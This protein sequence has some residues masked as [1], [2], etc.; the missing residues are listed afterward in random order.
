MNSGPC[1]FAKKSAA[2][3]RP[4]SVPEHATLAPYTFSEAK[5]EQAWQWGETG[6][7]GK[8]GP[9]RYVATDGRLLKECH[10]VDDKLHGA[11]VCYHDD[12]TVFYRSNYEHGVERFGQITRS[13][14]PSSYVFP[15]WC[16]D[17][18]W[19]HAKHYD[20]H[21]RSIRQE[22]RTRD[23]TLVNSEGVPQPERPAH[24]PD[25]AYWACRGPD[26]R[27]QWMLWTFDFSIHNSVG[28][29]AIWDADG[30]W[31]SLQYS[32]PT[33]TSTNG[34]LGL[35]PKTGAG[36]PNPLSVAADQNDLQAVEQLLALG[37]ASWPHMAEYLDFCC[38]LG[39]RSATRQAD[40][41]KFHELANRVR[42]GEFSASSFLA[43]PAEPKRPA[44]KE[45]PPVAPNAVWVPAMEGWLNFQYADGKPAGMWTARWSPYH[46]PK[47]VDIEFQDGRP[48]TR[49]MRSNYGGLWA[50]SRY[51]ENGSE[52]NA[53]EYGYDGVLHSEREIL[54]DGTVAEREFFPAAE[55]RMA[56]EALREDT[57]G[58]RMRSERIM[59]NN[60]LIVQRTWNEDGTLAEEYRPPTRPAN[61]PA[62]AG[63]QIWRKRTTNWSK[64]GQSEQWIDSHVTQ[65]NGQARG[66][67]RA[68]DAQGELLRIGYFNGL[69]RYAGYDRDEP[70]LG[71]PL[72]LAFQSKDMDAVEKLLGYGLGSCAH[73]AEHADFEC[74]PA[75]A[76]RLRAGNFP[77]TEFVDAR[78]EPQRPEVVS[79]DAVWVPNLHGWLRFELTEQVPTGV[80]TAWYTDA[81]SSYL[82]WLDI[83]FDHGRRV[84]QTERSGRGRLW[85]QWVY[86]E[87]GS[88]QIYRKYDGGQIEKETENFSDGSVATR[89]FHDQD[90][91]HSERIMRDD[92]LLIEK[93]WHEDGTLAAEVRPSKKKMGGKPVEIWRAFNAAG[94][95]IA[96]GPV[97]GYALGTWQ[98]FDARGKPSEKIDIGHDKPRRSAKL[99]E[100]VIQLAA[101]KNFIRPA[102]LEGIDKVPWEKLDSPMGRLAPERY[103]QCME[104]LASPGE[105]LAFGALGQLGCQCEHQGSIGTVTGG[106]VAYMCRLLAAGDI[107]SLALRESVLAFI[108]NCATSGQTFWWAQ[109]MRKE[110]AKTLDRPLPKLSKKDHPYVRIYRSIA[111]NLATW[112]KIIA[113]PVLEPTQRRQALALLALAPGKEAEQML[114][115]MVADYEKAIQAGRDFFEL[116]E[117]L[118]LLGLHGAPGDLELLAPYLADDRPLVRFSA[119]RTWV[120]IA[121]KRA[122]EALDTLVMG[123]ADKGEFADCRAFHMAEGDA[124]T[125]AA[126]ALTKLP[127]KVATRAVDKICAALPKTNSI[128]AVS[129]CAAL[130]VIVL[131]GKPYEEAS[132][133]TDIQRTALRAIC[134]ADNA[135]VFVNIKDAFEGTGLPADRQKLRSMLGY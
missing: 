80:W 51:A 12:G 120:R 126:V 104:D 39:V 11:S 74:L 91:L 14:N 44:D 48:I 96:E 1:D 70:G 72:I 43:P 75:L 86:A 46:Q 123:L 134:D 10:F 4:S 30:Q 95:R 99:G 21:G 112:Q 116:A 60:A 132:A 17:T 94:Q 22:S 119:A 7:K 107:R 113:D 23:G 68:W 35:F 28:V 41:A 45:Y 89:R 118:F 88:T 37:L 19:S 105:E 93:W 101:R 92:S 124:A 82:N 79:A 114:R 121:G 27:P 122:G 66:V 103:I 49:S 29:C 59:R 130:L 129:M 2:P 42:A 61:V 32:S 57:G 109:K 111:E 64:Q 16:A 77:P 87:D 52:Q 24:L 76:K 71:D 26:G 63:W 54:P 47:W 100:L 36:E 69:G 83:E 8:T 38:A 55:K 40:Y 6:P 13:E 102:A 9:W 15:S 25:A 5:E 125:T 81:D 58:Q 110:T 62:S 31:I 50:R 133:L 34:Q 115:G 53:R 20:E 84:V 128:N 98:L 106:V 131:A 108:I 97:H 90:K 56:P 67:E 3:Q 33:G 135:W 18:V 127:P 117:L 73:V 65:K 85:K 78:V